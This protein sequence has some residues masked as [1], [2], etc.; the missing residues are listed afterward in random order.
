MD[1]CALQ[2]ASS[3]SKHR[4]SVLLSDMHLVRGD[5]VR[6]GGPA[7]PTVCQRQDCGRCL[8]IR[9]NCRNGT[10]SLLSV[11]NVALFCLFSGMQFSAS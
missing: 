7:R 3:A 1:V 11:S 8:D 2:C 6:V 5:V 4:T 9:S 10:S